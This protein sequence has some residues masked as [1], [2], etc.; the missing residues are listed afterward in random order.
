VDPSGYFLYATDGKRIFAYNIDRNDGTLQPSLGS[1]YLIESSATQSISLVLD[2]NGHFLYVSDPVKKTLSMYPIY[3][4]DGSIHY[5]EQLPAPGGNVVMNSTGS[6]L[7]ETS[8]VSGASVQEVS[9]FSV[10][11]TTGLVTQIE[12]YNV[13]DGP[14]TDTFPPTIA[15]KYLYLPQRTGCC[16]YQTFAYEIGANGGLTPVPGSPFVS[17]NNFA[18]IGN[19]VADW[20]TRY[21]WYPGMNLSNEPAMQTSDIAG[22]TGALGEN[23]PTATGNPLYEYLAEDHSGQYLYAAGSAN[24]A[25]LCAEAT[26]TDVFASWSIGPNGQ[27]LRVSGPVTSGFSSTISET[28]AIATSR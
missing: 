17:N 1:P 24:Q 9:V 15:W 16:G 14:I 13:P 20:L 18:V 21:Y 11:Q 3:R 19:S 10:D 5:Y 28:I 23:I 27:L 22:S 26:C 2:P 8:Y 6:Y 25:S 4:S 12:S 7:F